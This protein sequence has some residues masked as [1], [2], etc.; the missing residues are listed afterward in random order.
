MAESVLRLTQE[1]FFLGW[2][3]HFAFTFSFFV[4]CLK[5]SNLENSTVLRIDL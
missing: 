1:Y 3:F 5:V 4:L 2:S